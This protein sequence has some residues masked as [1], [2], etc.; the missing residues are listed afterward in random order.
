M[1]EI[2][3]FTL[4]NENLYGYFQDWCGRTQG[5]PKVPRVV[6]KTLQRRGNQVFLSA[7]IEAGSHGYPRTINL[8]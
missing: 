6:V 1:L 5:I 4:H 3:F 8:L 7:M 2:T